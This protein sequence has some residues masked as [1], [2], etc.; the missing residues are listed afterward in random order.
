MEKIKKNISVIPL[1]ISLR[2]KNSFVI[3]FYE[4]IKTDLKK[5]W[6]MS[7]QIL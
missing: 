3:I 5:R 1:N 7:E 2:G 6:K 4:N